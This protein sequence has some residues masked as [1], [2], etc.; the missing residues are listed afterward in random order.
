MS[1]FSSEKHAR[2]AADEEIHFNFK[3]SD[4]MQADGDIMDFYQN[5]DVAPGGRFMFE[6]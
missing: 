2:F 4:N 6:F 5:G 1:A 3:L